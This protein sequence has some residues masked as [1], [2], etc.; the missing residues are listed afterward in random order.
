MREYRR[1][2]RA[3]LNAKRRE[4]RAK[5]IEMFRTG[6]KK[7]RKNNKEKIAVSAKKYWEANR[8]RLIVQKREYN[9]NHKEQRK[10]YYE[11]NRYTICYKTLN[12]GCF[13]SMERVRQLCPERILEYFERYPF[14]M[15]AEKQIKRQL[16][17]NGIN[18]S[19]DQYAECYDAGMLAYLYSIHRC[20]AL[21]CDYVIPYVLKMIRIYV[22]CALVV[23][24]ETRNL[25]RKN[26]FTEFRLDRDDI[27]NY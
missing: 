9:D 12:E 2:N 19:R 21:N 7:Y 18:P 16:Y 13:K 14:E 25:C 1:K 10:S 26:G 24:N 8:E 5:N 15:Y 20:A 22:I 27:P 11:K 17:R 23:S 4:Y 6:D 3:A